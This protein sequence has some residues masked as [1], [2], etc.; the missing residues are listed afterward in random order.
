M[1]IQRAIITAFALG[2]ATC[3]AG[4]A[5]SLSLGVDGDASSASR[6]QALREAPG[7]RLPD[8][9]GRIH[10]LKDF[11]GKVIVLH[12]WATWCPPCLEELPQWVELARRMEGQPIVWIAVSL[13]KSWEA[14][15]RY[16]RPEKLPGNVVS[17]LDAKSEAPELYGSYQFPESYLLTPDL[18]ILSKWVGPQPWDSERMAE[19]IRRLAELTVRKSP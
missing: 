19:A 13:D 16:L 10:D 7:L 2:I 8:D 1:T 15:H 4:Y 9:Q 14:A 17:L 18:K 11:R 3:G 5:L 12:F 6:K